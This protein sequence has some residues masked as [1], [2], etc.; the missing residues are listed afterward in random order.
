MDISERI[1][2]LCLMDDLF[3]TEHLKDVRCVELV[4]R[5]ILDRPG[6][7]V[8]TAPDGRTGTLT[9]SVSFG[10]GDDPSDTGGS[11][12]CGNVGFGELALLAC[13]AMLRRKRG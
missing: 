7:V 1:K 12:G 5:I 4:L 13:A 6:L 10:G 2:G 8:G 11:S 9:Q 3:M